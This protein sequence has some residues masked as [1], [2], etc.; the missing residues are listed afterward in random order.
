M[1]SDPVDECIVKEIELVL[2]KPTVHNFTLLRSLAYPRE[3]YK[4]LRRF[5]DEEYSADIDT[6]VSHGLR[7]C[8]T[9]V[10]PRARYEMSL[11]GAFM[12]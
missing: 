11:L 10:V 12:W 1:V 9:D 5:F 6:V 8:K 2:G 4:N 7:S 3:A